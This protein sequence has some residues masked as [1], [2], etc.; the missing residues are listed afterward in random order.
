MILYQLL[1]PLAKQG[2]IELP[3]IPSASEHNAHIVYFKVKDLE[4]RQALL[5]FLKVNKI[6]AVFHYVPLHSSEA[7]IRFGTFHG[8]DRFT[9]AESER[10]VRLP[11]FYE[12]TQENISYVVNK[13]L[14]FYEKRVR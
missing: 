11:L 14:E 5:V 9:T 3:Q 2:L 6:G 8:H 12:L 13:I 1:L 4:E 10:L 7:G